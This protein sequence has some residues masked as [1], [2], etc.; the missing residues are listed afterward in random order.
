MLVVAGLGGAELPR[1]YLELIGAAKSLAADL[2]QEV[3]FVAVGENAASAA[4]Q[5]TRYGVQKALA[6]N[7][8]VADHGTE[9]FLAG[10]AHAV[11]GLE[12]AAIFLPGDAVGREAAPRL[13]A[14][15]NGAALVD[16]IDA[17]VDGGRIVWT[18]PV[19]G[20]KALADYALKA[21]PAV[22]CLRPGSFAAAEETAASAQVETVAFED[23]Q[24]AL[25][26]V[27]RIAEQREGPRLD[28]ASVVVSGGRGLGGPEGFEPLKELAG[29]LG[30]AVGASLAAVDE[31]WAPAEWQVGQT[32]TMVSPDVY[33]A[34][35]ISGASQH[36]AGISGAKTVIAI[37]KDENAPIFD[38]ARFG[39]VM[40]YKKIM[41]ALIE[42]FRREYGN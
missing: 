42:A 33:F 22:V 21:A 38:A 26:I 35:A 1:S 4:E 23:G 30:G 9:S 3:A 39:I 8:N 15:L 24:H 11:A 27:E 32:G 13:A 36:L 14:R 34:V 6:V 28:E 12:P 41:P 5:A 20:G 19:F 25:R 37:N 10:L 17:R 40:D 16:V 29:I 2:N 7:A 31:G 18:R